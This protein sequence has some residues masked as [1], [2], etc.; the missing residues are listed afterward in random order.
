MNT[1]VSDFFIDSLSVR[2]PLPVF[3]QFPQTIQR[4]IGRLLGVTRKHCGELILWHQSSTM[5]LRVE[6]KLEIVIPITSLYPQDGL[7]L[8]CFV[9]GGI[10]GNNGKYPSSIGNIMVMDKTFVEALLSGN[11]AA[12]VASP[13][14][15]SAFD[16]LN[17]FDTSLRLNVC[18]A[19]LLFILCA[20]FRLFTYSP[21]RTTQC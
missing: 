20:Y 5:C 11:I 17:V 10:E 3:Q 4:V 7:L 2:I 12:L 19:L 15:S 8:D 13:L 6:T 9:I 1:N 16:N 18:G 14:L 21:L